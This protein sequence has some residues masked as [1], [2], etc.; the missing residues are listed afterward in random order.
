MGESYSATCADWCRYGG[1]DAMPFVSGSL[2]FE[3]RGTATFNWRFTSTADVAAF[4]S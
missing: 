3:I 4:Q 1:G 2:A